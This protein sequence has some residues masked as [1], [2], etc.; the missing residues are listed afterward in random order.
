MRDLAETFW[1]DVSVQPSMVSCWNWLGRVTP[2]GYGK[3][4]GH[5]A[6]RLAVWLSGVPLDSRLDVN[7]AC[8]NKLCCNPGHLQVLRHSDHSRVTRGQQHGI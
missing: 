3:H 8:R 6:H 4:R 7:H 5:A 2:S 1:R